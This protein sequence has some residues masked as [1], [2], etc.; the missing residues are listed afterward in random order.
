[1]NWGGIVIRLIVM[2]VFWKILDDD[3]KGETDEPV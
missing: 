1:V 2:V 3:A